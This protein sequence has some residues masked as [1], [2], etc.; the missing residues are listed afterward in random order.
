MPE[1][2][3]HCASACH[4]C[5]REGSEQQE[6]Y[7]LQRSFTAQEVLAQR[8]RPQWCLVSLASCISAL[9]LP[10]LL[11][12]LAGRARPGGFWNFTQTWWPRPPTPIL[13][14]WQNLLIRQATCHHRIGFYLR[15]GA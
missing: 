1:A 10:H 5:Q 6:S 2:C 14:I 9:G 11:V 15:P 3:P 4:P 13:F 8:P 7:F 12:P